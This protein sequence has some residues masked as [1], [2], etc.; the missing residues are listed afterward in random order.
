MGYLADGN[1]VSLGEVVDALVREDPASQQRV[2]FA[3]PDINY[4]TRRNEREPR[5]V[6]RMLRIF[7]AA[8]VLEALRRDEGEWSEA[9]FVGV[10][11][12]VERES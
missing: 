2:A 12:N 4:L 11:R 3:H 7:G 6:G 1:P 5:F 8:V 9:V 10:C